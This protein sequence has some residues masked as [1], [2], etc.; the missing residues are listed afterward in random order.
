MPLLLFS[1]DKSWRTRAQNKMV[2]RYCFFFKCASICKLNYT[3]ES[4]KWSKDA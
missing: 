2:Q 1:P 3:K 4:K